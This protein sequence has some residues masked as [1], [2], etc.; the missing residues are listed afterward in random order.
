[1]LSVLDAALRDGQPADRIH[2]YHGVRTEDDLYAGA[3]LEQRAREHGI[4]FVPVYAEGRRTSARNGHLHEAVALDFPDL[5]SSFIHVAGP[6][7][8]VAAVTDLA[9]NRGAQRERIRADA[10]HAAEPEKRGLWERVT[11]WGGITGWG[12]LS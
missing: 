12:G 9:V 3:L 11:G 6:P 1:M 10:F 4:R 2:V 5:A 8:M 7:P